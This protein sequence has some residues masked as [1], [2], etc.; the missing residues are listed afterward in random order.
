MFRPSASRL[1]AG[2]CVAV[3]LLV[4]ADSSSR[5]GNLRGGKKNYKLDASSGYQSHDQDQENDAACASSIGTAS[6]RASTSTLTAAAASAPPAPSTS[7]LSVDHGHGKKQGR[8]HHHHRR[9]LPPQQPL[10]PQGPAMPPQPQQHVLA[11]GPSGSLQYVPQAAVAPQD[12]STGPVAPLPAGGAAPSAPTP[13][14]KGFGKKAMIAQLQK[15]NQGFR[16]DIDK[17][18]GPCPNCR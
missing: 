7:L 1:V 6:V 11:Q 13:Q 15:S 9:A 18:R 8:H 10:V 3:P 16:E 2:A 12:P 4:G 14:K 5:R 17:Q